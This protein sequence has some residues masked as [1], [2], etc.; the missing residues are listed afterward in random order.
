MPNTPNNSP[1]TLQLTFRAEVRN[2]RTYTATEGANAGKTYYTADAELATPGARWSTIRLRVRSKSPI[3]AGSAN[4]V[5]VSMD[6][7]KGEG[8]ADILSEV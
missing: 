4:L 8:I 6:G 5:M 2:P 3:V 1:A 7:A